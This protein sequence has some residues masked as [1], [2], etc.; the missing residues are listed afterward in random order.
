MIRLTKDKIALIAILLV[1]TISGWAQSPPKDWF[2][3]DPV[4]DHYYGV[5]A[6]R[7]YNELLKGKTSQ[8]VIVDN[9]DET[10]KPLSLTC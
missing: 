1:F 4:Q 7:A 2:L 8:T 10:V 5:S 9:G 3:L 6:E